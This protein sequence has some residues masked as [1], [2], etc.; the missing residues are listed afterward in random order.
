VTNVLTEIGHKKSANEPYIFYKVI[1]SRITIVALYVDDF[2]VVSNYSEEKESL[3]G[4]L[5][6]RFKTKDLREAKQILRMGIHQDKEMGTTYID[7]KKYIKSVI[8]K[9]GMTDAKRL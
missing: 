4:E 7:Q 9:F 2:L 5:Q 1:G 6:A 3:K 8:A